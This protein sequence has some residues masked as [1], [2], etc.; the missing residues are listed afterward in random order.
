MTDQIEYDRNYARKYNADPVN[1]ARRLNLT[2]M[3]AYG[4]GSVEY[5][6]MFLR[7]EGKCAICGRHQSAFKRKLGIDHSH[8]TG[9]IRGLLC[10]F[11]NRFIVMALEASPRLLESAKAYLERSA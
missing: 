11:C 4:I 2:R 5:D 6:A 10:M 3:R 1:I 8:A 9:K 7:Q